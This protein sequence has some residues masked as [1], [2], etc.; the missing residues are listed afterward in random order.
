MIYS[1]NV[2]HWLL[3]Y[4]YCNYQTTTVLKTCN[5]SFFDIVHAHDLEKMLVCNWIVAAKLRYI[6]LSVAVHLYIIFIYVIFETIL[7]FFFFDLHI[8]S[9]YSYVTTL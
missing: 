5:N 4:L 7:I 8:L 3:S 9:K 6:Y 2:I 1:S